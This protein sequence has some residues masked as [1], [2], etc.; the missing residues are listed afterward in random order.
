MTTKSGVSVSSQ[1]REHL[2][3]KPKDP[4]EHEDSNSATSKWFRSMWRPI[5]AF[6]YFAI[7]I[8]D[9][10]I[11]PY[12]VQASPLN[13]SEIIGYV[14]QMPEEQRAEALLTLTSKQQ[15]TSLTSSAGGLFHIAFGA[16]LGASAWTRGLEK[17]ER[18]ALKKVADDFDDIEV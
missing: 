9:F 3:V 6:V 2:T 7:C 17:R 13:L 8:F 18:I 5:A 1:T 14:L 16:I 12:F 4:F 11:A 15:W 10:I